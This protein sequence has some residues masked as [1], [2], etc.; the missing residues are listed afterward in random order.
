MASSA[1]LRLID[2]AGK[3]NL[4]D[5]NLTAEMLEMLP[6]MTAEL[7]AA[8]IDWRDTNTVAGT[9]GAVLQPLFPARIG[10]NRPLRASRCPGQPETAGPP[11][12]HAA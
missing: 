1:D 3:L 12:D 9:G 2:E 10:E 8:I 11:D 7:A 6:N 4:N 5:T